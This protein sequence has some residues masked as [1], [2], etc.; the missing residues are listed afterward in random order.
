MKMMGMELTHIGK[1][2]VV[3]TDAPK[4]AHAGDAPKECFPSLYLSG[5]EV[6]DAL[7]A[8]EHDDQVIVVAKGRISNV[9][10]NDSEKGKTYTVTL[11]LHE[12][13]VK[14]YTKKKASEMTEEE[15]TE[16][17]ENGD[18]VDEG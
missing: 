3:E 8:M 14:P 16:A 2:P 4:S 1:K 12:L 11:E 5:H 18:E 10:T 13:G 9:G 17:L 15:A 7:K 6:P